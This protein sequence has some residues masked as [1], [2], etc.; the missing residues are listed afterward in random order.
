METAA[1]GKKKKRKQ[2]RGLD[3]GV[4]SHFRITLELRHIILKYCSEE[5][6]VG[7]L[8]R[9]LLI[10]PG[11]HCRLD[12]INVETQ[13]WIEDEEFVVQTAGGDMTVKR[14]AGVKTSG[15]LREW[16]SLKKKSP[17]LFEHVEVMAQ[18][19]AV[20]DS[21]ITKWSMEGM[22]KRH[23][24]TLWMRDSCGGGGKSK[25]GESLAFAVN[26]C[27]H[28]IAG[29]MTSA[30]QMTDTDFSYR[31]KCFAAQCGR[32]IKTEQK[33]AAEQSREGVH[34]MEHWGCR[35]LIDVVHRSLT[36]LKAVERAENLTLKSASRNGFLA[37]RPNMKTRKLYD[38]RGEKWMEDLPQP[39]DSHRLYAEWL[40]DRWNWC[41]D[42][43]PTKPEPVQTIG[44]ED[45]EYPED[46]DIT[47]A[48][49][50]QEVQRVRGEEFDEIL[51]PVEIVGRKMARQIQVF[52]GDFDFEEKV[53]EDFQRLVHMQGSFKDRLRSMIVDAD[54]RMEYD[55]RA[56]Q[57]KKREKHRRARAVKRRAA[58]G[59][60]A[61][62]AK[63]LREKMRKR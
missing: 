21:L 34:K 19:C 7:L 29:K 43:V 20:V 47:T 32:E 30:V 41:E 6:P 59:G 39:A 13:T 56:K 2:T 27:T 62:D 50:P 60:K 33:A 40:A 36:K 12:N 11:Q 14:R 53:A 38:P 61:D 22:Q 35:E 31:V 8:D 58:S 37:W 57:L 26:Q 48:P 46:W 1:P 55:T 23:G 42:G 15:N 63:K 10:V 45:A 5:D 54:V 24:C 9:T 49:G 25:S 28:F 16:V 44:D 3:Q 18:P 17:R 4:Q 52:V 51:G